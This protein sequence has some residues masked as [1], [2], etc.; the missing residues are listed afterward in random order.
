MCAGTNAPHGYPSMPSGVSCVTVRGTLGSF[1]VGAENRA[2]AGEAE[3]NGTCGRVRARL[4]GVV[5][6]VLT[7]ALFAASA[8]AAEQ[9]AFSAAMNYATPVVNVGQGDTLTL[10]NLDQLARHD[11]VGENGQFKS[12]LLAGGESGPVRGVERLLQGTF[13]FHCSLH[14][15]M[16]GGINLGP[17][18]TAVGTPSAGSLESNPASSESPDPAALNQRAVASK[19]GPGEWPVYGHDL[20]NSRDGGKFGPSP[21][22]VLNLGVAWSF[23]SSHGDFTGTPVVGQGLVAVG[24]N[25]GRVFAI[26]ASTGEQ[27]WHKD[28]GAPV[29]GTLA[30]DSG[31]VVVPIARPHAPAL[32]AFEMY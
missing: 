20:A 9:H 23:F 12:D 22:D 28:M 13:A 2:S 1:S 15:W 8:N 31:R 4:V 14:S 30:V 21:A 10:T 32:A 26:N 5:T 16:R 17:A 29:N 11:I 6:A 19:I 7:S 27:E 25:E 3:I 24:S 18:G